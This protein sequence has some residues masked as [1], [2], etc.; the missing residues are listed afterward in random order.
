MFRQLTVIA[1]KEVLDHAREIRSNVATV[2][3]LFMGPLLVLLVS[4][5]FA[6]KSGGKGNLVVSGMVSIFAL[7]AVFVGGMNVSMDLMAGERERRSLLPLLL[8]PA[9]RVTIIAG[10]WLATSFFSVAGL[11]VT[12][13]AFAIVGRIGLIPNPLFSRSGLLCWVLLGLIP[14]TFLAAA[15]QLAIST[16]SR[17][18]KEAQTYLSLLIF[19]PMGIGMFLTFFPQYIG[20]WT[21]FIPILGQQSI[22]HA[23]IHGEN[24]SV[25][26]AAALALVTSWLTVVTVVVSGKLLEQDGIVYGG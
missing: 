8:S 4:F 26:R 13:G 15:L 5:S 14:L 17:T 23:G 25:A 21:D 18:V 11:A 2:A 7:V 12:I 22:A 19:I 20:G 3:H 24:W 9:S 16:A 1:R 10:K 6:A